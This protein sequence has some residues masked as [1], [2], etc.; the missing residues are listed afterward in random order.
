MKSGTLPAVTTAAQHSI[1][2][3]PSRADLHTETQL[4]GACS[5]VL[6]AVLQRLERG[7]QGLQTSRDQ[8]A[9]LDQLRAALL[10]QVAK[11]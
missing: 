11:P 7:A 6:A 3:A 2:G 1:P 9:A 5:G 10:R 8:H 4:C